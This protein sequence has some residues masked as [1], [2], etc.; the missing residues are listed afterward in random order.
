[1]K[2]Q[3]LTSKQFPGIS[4]YYTYLHEPAHISYTFGGEFNGGTPEYLEIDI[5][6][7]KT[8][9]VSIYALLSD[10][11]LSDLKEEI[12]DALHPA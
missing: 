5:L 6:D 4:V 9:P 10:A 8:G 3:E 1:M 7:V 12:A 2:T 11:A